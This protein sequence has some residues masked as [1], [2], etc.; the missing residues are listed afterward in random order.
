ML[1]TSRTPG[2]PFMIVTI[3]APISSDVKPAVSTCSTLAISVTNSQPGWTS[4]V[5]FD[6][7][8]DDILDPTDPIVTDLSQVAAALGD[9][10][11][12]GGDSIDLFVKV[13]APA[14]ADPGDA[15]ESTLS[16]ASA[17]PTASAINNTVVITGDVELIKEQALDADCN[18]T[19]DAPFTTFQISEGSVP[20]ACILY[21]ITA[22]N[23]GPDTITNLVI[24]DVTP[25]FTTLTLCLANACTPAVDVGSITSPN[26]ATEGYTGLVTATV[27]NLDSL[28]S[29]VFTFGVKIDGTCGASPL[30]SCSAP[31]P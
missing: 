26:P 24:N 23:T 29:A 5:Y 22:S 16:V 12:D 30:P 27:G 9:G 15:D 19:E 2:R 21:R 25:T 13:F 10:S 14:G 7:N 4:V 8:G 31:S 17:A 11:F 1:S 28:D 3:S 6:A 20:A 18:G